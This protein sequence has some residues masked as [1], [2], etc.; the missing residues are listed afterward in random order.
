MLYAKRKFTMNNTLLDYEWQPTPQ[1]KNKLLALN[2]FLCSIS[3][4]EIEHVRFQLHQPIDEVASSTRS[5]IKSKFKEISQAVLDCIAPG[6]SDK[7][8]LLTEEKKSKEHNQSNEMTMDTLLKL[9]DASSSWYTKEMILSIFASHYT[10]SK[11]QTMIPGLPV[12]RIDRARS[13]SSTIGTAEPEEKEPVVRYRLPQEKL[14][15]FLD[16]TSTPRFLQD[17]AYGTRHLK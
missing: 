16:F 17:V 9:Y 12:W 6:Q 10:K 4:G 2:T 3:D 15:N 14:D 8:R 11:L 1:A 5:Y 7:W 13:H